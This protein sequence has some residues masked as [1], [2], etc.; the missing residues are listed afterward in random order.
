[1]M[2]V[3]TK[4]RDRENYLGV[5]SLTADKSGPWF[6]VLDKQVIFCTTSPAALSEE[7]PE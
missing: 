1:M 6:N 3:D 2:F 5:E 4:V 7:S